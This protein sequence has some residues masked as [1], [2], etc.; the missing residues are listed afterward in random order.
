VPDLELFPRAFGARTVRFHAGLELRTLNAAL[1]ALR[2][3]RAAHL[4]PPLAPLAPLALRGSLALYSRGSKNGALAVWARGAPKGAPQEDGIER[5]IALVTADDG[6]ATPSSPAVLLA[7]KLLLGVGLP[8]GAYPC[9]GL[10]DLKELLAHLEPLGISCARDLGDGRWS[11][12][13]RG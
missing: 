6:P 2:A 4:I 9:M 3:L 13:G 12:Q 1:S 11:A 8:A 5:G 10:L 7:R